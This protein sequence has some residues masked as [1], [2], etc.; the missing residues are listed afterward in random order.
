[1]K[2]ES[3][4]DREISSEKG[5]SDGLVVSRRTFLSVLGCSVAAIAASQ[6]GKAS[7]ASLVLSPESNAEFTDISGLQEKYVATSCLNCPGRCAIIVRTVDGKAV[8]IAG[9]PLSKVSDG[10]ICPR[11]HIGPQVLYDGE[12]IR[13]PL[14]RTTSAKGRGMDPGWVPISW[15]RAL[16]ELTKHL[17]ELRS[18]GE[19][20]RLLLFCGLNSRSSEDVILRFA[21]AYGTPNI[22]PDEAVESEAEKFG[23]WM[24]EGNRSEVVYDLSRT[25]YLLTFGANLLESEVPLSVVL[26]DWGKMRREKAVR[27]KVVAIDPRYSVTAAKADEW[28]PIN[29]GTDA[30]LALGLAHV[31]IQEG[32]YDVDFVDNNCSGFTAF[33]QLV[34]EDYAP[35]RAAEITGVDAE[36]IRRLAREFAQTRPAIAWIGRGAAGW[37]NGAYTT[38]AIYCLNALAGSLDIPGG[39]IYPEP[40]PYHAMPKV[41]DDDIARKSKARPRIG[42]GQ[43]AE[44]I[45]SGEP[46]PADVAIGFNINLNMSAP[47]ARRWDEALKKIPFYIHLAPFA[48]EMA[49]YADIL[50]PTTTYLEEWGYEHSLSGPTEIRLKQPV[51]KP[52]FDTRSTGDIIFETAQRIGGNIANSFA[53]IGDE[54]EG[55]VS[56]RTRGLIDWGEFLDKGVWVGSDYQYRKYTEIF[57][58][59]SGKF[60][61]R[62]GNYESLVKE[63]GVAVQSEL[64]YLPHYESSNFLGSEADYPLMLVT[65]HPAM[66][67]W[68]GSQNYPWAQEIF[69]VMHGYGWNNFVEINSETARAH[70]IEDGDMAWVE[71]PFGKLMVKARVFEGIHPGVV[72]ISLGEGH[73]AYGRWQKGIGVNPNDIIGMDYDRI[74]RQSAFFNTRVRIY[75]A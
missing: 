66:C 53:G 71:S 14:R 68:N 75:K 9:N 45:I 12:R 42:L 37:P 13:T 59:F 70:G 61:F 34:L 40:P 48:S 29:P 25:N 44:A 50:L 64:A 8:K 73:Y 60:E 19:P 4:G 22:I 47:G 72:S 51:V 16:E 31:I 3:P 67:L 1:M 10:K 11:A 39:V 41:E 24:A 17:T 21:E 23:R 5:K 58:T 15:D 2:Q 18:L 69:L 63:K 35:S 27:G 54:M 26:R 55:F 6:L 57:K 46:Y 43:T 33:K 52:L 7:G 36:R 20:H 30:A 38:Y 49:Q 28:I 56:Y 74:S 65:Y 32:L 62:S